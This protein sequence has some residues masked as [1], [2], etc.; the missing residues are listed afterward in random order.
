MT[1]R[2]SLIPFGLAAAFVLAG[3]LGCGAV[4]PP[5]HQRAPLQAILAAPDDAPDPPSALE[6]SLWVWE[7]LTRVP[8]R[9]E[10][11]NLGD[12]PKPSEVVWLDAQHFLVVWN[13]LTPDNATHF[14]VLR[15]EGSDF[16]VVRRGSK[17]H[18]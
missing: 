15:H 2:R 6:V 17:E 18:G 16:V 7:D 13:E 5:V 1:R 10:R 3:P 11:W 4:Q 8:F 9:T 12:V 14:A